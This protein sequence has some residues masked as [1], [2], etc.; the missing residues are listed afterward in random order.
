MDKIYLEEINQKI[1]HEIQSLIRYASSISE[2]AD[3]EDNK[4]KSLEFVFKSL[5]I[6]YYLKNLVLFHNDAEVNND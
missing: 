5:N 4:E 3:S 1:D 6:Y 2:K